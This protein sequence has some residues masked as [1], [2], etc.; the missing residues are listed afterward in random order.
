MS[1]T[2]EYIVG[3]TGASGMAYAKSTIRGLLQ[4]GYSVSCIVS[5]S[6]RRVLEVEENL[7][8]SG[9]PDQDIAVFAKW[10]AA[11]G[12]DRLELFHARN[13]AARI[14]SGSAKFIGMAVVPCSGGTLARI[15]HGLSS[16]LIERVA[17]V[18]LKERR[19]LVLVQR[20][21]P[22]SLVHIRNM[23]MAKEAG[24][25]ILPASPGFYHNPK[26]VQDLVDMIAGRVLDCLG[27][28]TPMLKR[29]EGTPKSG[30]SN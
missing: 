3:I 30:L 7:S 10:C 8:L 13:V 1:D 18:C 22:L 5:D 6:G 16:G 29:W 12:K 26:T 14:A 17:D 28:S 2:R 21:T 4:N 23:G 20:E 15:A 25:V 19:T 27:V 24:A 9:Q 11:D